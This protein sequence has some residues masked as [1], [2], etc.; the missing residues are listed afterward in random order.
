MTFY[1]FPVHQRETGEATILRR[2]C[3]PDELDVVVDHF[4]VSDFACSL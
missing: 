1:P 4:A 2:L 3:W